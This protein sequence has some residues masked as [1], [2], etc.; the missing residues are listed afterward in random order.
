[1]AKARGTATMEA[2]REATLDVS[3]EHPALTPLVRRLAGELWEIVRAKAEA[4]GL[5]IE[6]AWLRGRTDVEGVDEAYVAV[7]C[8]APAER[9]FAFGD[10]LNDDLDQW[11]ATLDASD[12]ETA[13]GLGLEIN[14]NQTRFPVSIAAL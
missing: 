7:L 2:P 12:R 13:M 14:W 8:A 5:P 3:M 11:F 6:K 1:M 9:T 10:G 4:E